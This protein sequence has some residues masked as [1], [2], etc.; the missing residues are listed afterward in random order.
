RR[1]SSGKKSTKF[2]VRRISDPMLNSNE[3][4][5]VPHDDLGFPVSKYRPEEGNAAHSLQTTAADYAKFLLAMLQPQGLKA[6]TVELILS[7]VVELAPSS[8]GPAPKSPEISW[9]LGWGLQGTSKEKAFWHW[10]DNNTFRCFVIAYPD[11]RKGVVYF[12]NSN[13]TPPASTNGR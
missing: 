6:S 1:G 10:G 2:C 9:G 4:F 11:K 7:P 3:N 13:S 5:A 8:S 12:T